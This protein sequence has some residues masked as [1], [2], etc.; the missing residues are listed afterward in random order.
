MNSKGLFASGAW[1]GVDGGPK[2]GSERWTHQK[3]T[4][5]DENSPTRA[6]TESGPWTVHFFFVSIAMKSATFFASAAGNTLVFL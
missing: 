2:A 3:A 5:R 6:K 4:V 1:I